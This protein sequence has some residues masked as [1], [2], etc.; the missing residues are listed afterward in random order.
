MQK[1]N[2]EQEGERDP[3]AKESISEEGSNQMGKHY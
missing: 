1:K 3:N 2:R